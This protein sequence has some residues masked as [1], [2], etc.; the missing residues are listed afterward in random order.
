ME[1][2]DDR[3]HLLEKIKL[4]EQENGLLKRENKKLFS[5]VHYSPATIVVTDLDG[6]IEYANPGFTEITGYSKEEAVGLNPR[7]LKSGYHN[8]DF[9]KDMWST[10]RS[11]N[12]WQGEF[13]NK[14]KNGDYYWEQAHIAP[15]KDEQGN[16][17]HFVAI[18]FDI[19]TKVEA[20]S[21]LKSII[22]AIPELIFVIDEEGRYVDMM[23]ADIDL[24]PNIKEKYVGKQID[25]VFSAALAEKL[26]SFI[27]AT[28][29]TGENHSIEYEFENPTG[30][31]W[32]EGRS[33][34]LPIRLNDKRCVVIA[35]HDISYRKKAEQ[36]LMELN[37][38]KD[39][40]FTILG[41]DLKN[42]FWAILSFSEMLIDHLKDTEHNEAVQY[43][44]HIKNA[45]ELTFELVDNLLNWARSQTGKI[46]FKP[47]KFL[48][49]EL[50]SSTIQLM[51]S[52]AINKQVEL[53]ED[54]PGNLLVFADLNLTKTVL[55]NLIA[56]AIKYTPV[57]GKI[58]VS[59]IT[60]DNFVQVYVSD[61]GIGIPPEIQRKLFRI[62]AKYTTLGT[63]Q[64]KGTG[65]GLVLCKEFV[66]LQ[67]G[68]IWV[69][70]E[71]NVGSKFFFTLPQKS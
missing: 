49:H 64:E 54:V 44:K 70:S 15:I 11:G 1:N 46:E 69:E 17:T 21:Y 31:V 53:L 18:K 3:E 23:S 9:Y 6:N 56:N 66:E 7:L 51:E 26:R 4:L 50:I 67:G 68:K 12:V 2:Q 13:H 52:Q 22:S 35:A 5:A 14:K 30:A 61:T 45:A 36:D 10:I 37:A 8:V 39:K 57:T 34:L 40:F 62:D 33:A 38:T 28:I 71:V 16:I 19:T 48:L 65:L 42:P 32:Y 20:E 29:E 43:A 41:H 58:R 59:A 63:N 24:L 60:K 55:R 25:E 27:L 47:R